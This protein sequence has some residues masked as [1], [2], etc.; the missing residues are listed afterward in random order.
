M[1]LSFIFF[2]EKKI[3]GYPLRSGLGHNLQFMNQLELLFKIIGLGSA[4]GILYHDNTITAIGDNSSYL[5]Q[6]QIDSQKL[7]KHPLLY[8]AAENILK[9]EKPDFEA[10]TK[11]QENI[12]IFG[13]GSTKNRNI[14]IQIDAKTNKVIATNDMTN[15]Y[16]TMQSFGE[17]KPDDFN[18]EGAIYN[19]E[20]WFLVNRGNGKK[21]KNT[22][23]T[24]SGNNLVD[25]FSIIVNDFK[26]PKLNGIETSFTDSI[27]FNNKIY[28]LATAEDTVSTYDDGEILGSIIGR[29]DI[30]TMEIDFHQKISDNLKLEGLAFFEETNENITFLICEDNDTELLESNIYKLTLPK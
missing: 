19:G 1:L 2:K 18:L 7:Q 12:F 28:F 15:L 17:I 26:L 3:K 22:I 9:K 30:K 29:I 5:Y 11:H 13:S 16:A 10:I 23:F 6:Y 24:I 4:S 27:L 14:M 20:D 25:D 21:S 8:L